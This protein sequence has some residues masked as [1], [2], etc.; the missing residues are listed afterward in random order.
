MAPESMERDMWSQKTDVWSLGVLVYE[1]CSGGKVPYGI[2]RS[3]GEIQA[4]VIA[5]ERLPCAAD[6]SRG[7][8]DII[9]QCGRARAAD[10]PSFAELRVTIAGLALEVPPARVGGGGR[11]EEAAAFME[12]QVRLLLC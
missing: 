7:V 3:N 9:S 11:K 5:G 8:C 1:L 6:W 12:P 2:G 4:A 10:R